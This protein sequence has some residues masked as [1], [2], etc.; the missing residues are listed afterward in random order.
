MNAPLTREAI[1]AETQPTRD[2]IQM[3]ASRPG[4][5]VGH[6]NQLQ[7]GGAASVGT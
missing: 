5:G 3:S 6:L 7:L 1:A 2:G 4:A